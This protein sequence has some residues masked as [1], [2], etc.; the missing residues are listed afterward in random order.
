M[1]RQGSSTK[2]SL[3]QKPH[4]GGIEI[5]EQG[6]LSCLMDTLTSIM[7]HHVGQT[8]VKHLRTYSS[9]EALLA[10]DEET[11]DAM[12][13]FDK[14]TPFDRKNAFDRKNGLNYKCLECHSSGHKPSHASKQIISQK[15]NADG[16]KDDQATM[17]RYFEQ[18]RVIFQMENDNSIGAVKPQQ[19]EKMGGGT[20]YQQE[21]LEGCAT[22]Y[23][24]ETG[25]MR[26]QVPA[27]NWKD[28][29]PSTWHRCSAAGSAGNTLDPTQGELLFITHQS[30]GNPWKL[31]HIDPQDAL[32]VNLRRRAKKAVVTGVTRDS[33]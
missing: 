4:Q 1:N 8:R 2:T 6:A 7:G 14:V 29:Q 13:P 23:Q 25:R 30:V 27:R 26:N 21:N 17:E 31:L 24:Q 19:Q 9:L 28:A 15:N 33:N 12:P 20:K 22:K 18:I 11:A 32:C 3:Q 10:D 16:T 5:I